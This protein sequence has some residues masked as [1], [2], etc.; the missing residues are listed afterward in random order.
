MK[1]MLLA[2][3]SSGIG[4]VLAAQLL[5]GGLYGGCEEEAALGD[6]ALVAVVQQ[7]LVPG[8]GQGEGTVLSILMMRSGGPE[9]A[10]QIMDGQLFKMHG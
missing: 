9:R 10:R 2:D 4:R 1:L 5:E 8:G 7:S 6:V 3:H